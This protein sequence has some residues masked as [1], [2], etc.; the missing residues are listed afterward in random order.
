MKAAVK[1]G[2][3]AVTLSQPFGK[4]MKGLILDHAYTLLGVEEKDGQQLVR[5]R[6]PWGSFE[7]GSD[8]KDD[9]VF[10][11]PVAEYQKAFT[12]MEYVTPGMH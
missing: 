12:M 10:T 9:G 8:G 7:S 6:N 5:L 2:G 1:D 4:P 11:M 3:C